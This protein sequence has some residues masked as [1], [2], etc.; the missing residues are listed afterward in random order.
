MAP[1]Q[2]SSLPHE[3]WHVVQQR[4]GR[5][6]ADSQRRGIGVNSSDTLEREA[7]VMGAKAMRT[8]GTDGA[9][10]AVKAAAVASP[11]AQLETRS[12]NPHANSTNI[13]GWTSTAH[14][15]VSHA[16]LTGKLDL[17]G[18]EDKAEVYREAVPDVL[19]EEMVKNLGCGIDAT[20]P[21]AREQLRERLASHKEEDGDEVEFHGAK[22]GNMRA[23]FFEWQGGNQ[24]QGPN[25]SI[26]A[27]PT[28]DKMGMDVDG[29]LFN[30]MGDEDFEKMKKLGLALPDL[31]DPAEIKKNLLALLELTKN[32]DVAAYKGE[33]W[34]EIT[35]PAEVDRLAKDVG[36]NRAHILD[37][38]WLRANDDQIGVG[39]SLAD[40]TPV[41]GGEYAYRGEGQGKKI[42]TAGRFVYVSYRDAKAI[43]PANKT[44]KGL[45]EHL[46][47]LGVN[48]VVRGNDVLVPKDNVID[49]SAGKKAQF[50]VAGFDDVAIPAKSIEDGNY[51]VAKQL[52]D[53]K[54]FDTTKPGVPLFKYG[55]DNGMVT[56][57]FLPKK[58]YE[59][60]LPKDD[61][62]ETD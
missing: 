27:E 41:S 58:V 56:S 42:K 20:D 13:Q 61:V 18:E 45:S 30:G 39:K 35:D 25:T 55:T 14:H 12:T 19:T 5:V 38:T 37:Y 8:G 36:F 23:S 31:V 29:G 57:T 6:N 24:F 44:D 4:Q 60:T 40:I 34:V 43:N 48:T 52:F 62:E 51:V 1:G 2:E 10:P 22:L 47:E 32:R 53:K 17:L 46:T 26:R 33:D 7:D 49:K 59:A 16:V 28:D 54:R 3:A 11:V 50:A 9:P 15:I 21:E